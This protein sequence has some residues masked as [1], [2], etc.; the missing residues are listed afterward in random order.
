MKKV[1]SLS[2]IIIMF[3]LIVVKA[4]EAPPPGQ[5]GASQTT[6][7]TYNGATTITQNTT[8]NNGSYISNTPLQNALL[9]RAG[10]SSLTSPNIKK[11]GDAND[12]SSD[13]Y[14]TNAAVLAI[15][16]SVLNLNKATIATN[17]K[18][19]NGVFAY[20]TGTI[21][22]INSN[23]VTS[24]NN[25]GGIMVAGGGKIV[26]NDNTVETTGESSA[27]IRSDRGGGDITVERGTYKTS[28]S[29]SPV[30]YSTALISVDEATLE[31]TT[32]EGIVIEGS[33]LV[34]I[35]NTTLTNTNT[36]L[37]G[38]SETYKNIFLY[39][40]MSGDAEEGSST[41][42][43]TNSKIT[44]NKGDTIFV[45]NTSSEIIL[46]GNT[47]TNNDSTGVLLRAQSGKWGTSGSNGGKVKLTLKSQ[48]VEGD[49][50]LD[51]ISSLDLS[52]S[53]NSL[54]KGAI[55]NDKQGKVKLSI[56]S[57]SKFILQGDSYV[58]SLDNGNESNENIY[59]NGHKLYVNGKVVKINNKAYS[60]KP[61]KEE[62]KKDYSLYYYIGAGVIVFLL[63]LIII[64]IVSKKKKEKQK[65]KQE[66]VVQ[67]PMM[68]T[69]PKSMD[70][71]YKNMKR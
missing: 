42:K 40:S 51:K 68:D 54:Y 67:L 9:V 8:K 41:F 26:S 27:A 44:T 46:E 30:I 47:I 36:K 3:S 13:F 57:E 61:V 60:N 59:A 10:E 48:E 71:I 7:P 49:M 56:S 15:N 38:N 65:Q 55:N 20:G 21:N 33:N 29:G 45:T 19:A 25:S 5:P 58:D 64:I 69:T 23:I 22:L 37:H 11:L 34:E 28:G 2:L 50:V 31:S 39:Q 62:K 35:N 53:D 24:N 14:G 4:V 17:G 12:E 52:I 43:A 18:Y 32:A 6:T 1:I 63:L 66:Q 16:N 70:E